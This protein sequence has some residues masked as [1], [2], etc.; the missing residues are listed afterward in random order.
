MVEHGSRNW[1]LSDI[2]WN[3]VLDV[4]MNNYMRMRRRNLRKTI[5]EILFPLVAVAIVFFIKTE[6]PADRNRD[7][8]DSMQCI[9][10]A[11]VQESTTSLMRRVSDLYGSKN[12]FVYALWR[13]AA[14]FSTDETCVSAIYPNKS[15]TVTGSASEEELEKSREHKVLAVNMCVEQSEEQV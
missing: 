10:Y 5:C 3:F 12:H 8:D 7:G 15:L 14:R 1:M 9:V 2:P 6:R 4:K 11:P 13:L